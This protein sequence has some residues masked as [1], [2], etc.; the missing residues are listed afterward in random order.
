MTTRHAASVVLAGALASLAAGCAS[1]GASDTADGPA[2]A[3]CAAAPRLEGA[4]LAAAFDSLHALA[5]RGRPAEDL[6]LAAHDTKPRLANADEV[7]RLLERNFPRALR[8]RTAVGGVQVTALIDASGKVSEVRLMRGSDIED[9]NRATLTVMRG[10]R[11]R[12]ASREGCPVPFFT[13][14]PVNWS[15]VRSR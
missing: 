12:P 4:R 9:L 1:G 13:V 14:L 5:V 3:S 8:G 7:E 10:M 15:T 2:P 11:F 6:V